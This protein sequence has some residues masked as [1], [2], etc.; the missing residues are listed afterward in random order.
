MPETYI[1]DFTDA[2]TP[3]DADLLNIQ[4]QVNGVWLNYAI[5]ALNVTNGMLR[6]METFDIQDLQS[7][8]TQVLIPAPPSGTFNKPMF[9]WV[10]YEA[11]SVFDGGLFNVGLNDSANG[12]FYGGASFNFSPGSAGAPIIPSSQNV[13]PSPAGDVEVTI[14]QGTLADGTITILCEYLQ[15]FL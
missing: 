9:A 15:V 1:Q 5:S 13:N 11:G 4:R 7:G 3:Q 10:R 12:A 14:V 2:G 8:Q 6:V